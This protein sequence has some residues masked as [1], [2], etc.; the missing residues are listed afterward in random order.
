VFDVVCVVVEVV[1]AVVAEHGLPVTVLNSAP[2]GQSA[3][4]AAATGGCKSNITRL[5]AS[6][7]EIIR[8]IYK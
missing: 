6:T 8:F 2:G 4:A 5:V 1:A 7:T 3:D